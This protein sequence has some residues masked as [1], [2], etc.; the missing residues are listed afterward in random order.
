MAGFVGCCGEG[1]RYPGPRRATAMREL[2]RLALLA[3]EESWPED[4]LFIRE[5]R[6]LTPKDSE[7]AMDWWPLPPLM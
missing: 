6:A 3:D 2:E 4:I 7:P 1:I 5:A